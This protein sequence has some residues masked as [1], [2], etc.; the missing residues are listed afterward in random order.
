MWSA[1]ERR[2]SLFSFQK[3]N[4]SSRKPHFRCCCCCCCGRSI[5]ARIRRKKNSRQTDDFRLIDNVALAQGL[6]ATILIESENVDCQQ[7][8]QC[9]SKYLPRQSNAMEHNPVIKS[10]VMMLKVIQSFD[11]E[12][13]SGNII[14]WITLRSGV[15][16]LTLRWFRYVWLIVISKN[17]MMN[18]IQSHD[19]W[20]AMCVCV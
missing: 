13:W 9:L 19:V 6:K 15:C 3:F 12:S 2:F 11:C 17:H 4:H 1:G 16:W 18:H 5:K 14:Q 8:R 7:W 20:V 10:N